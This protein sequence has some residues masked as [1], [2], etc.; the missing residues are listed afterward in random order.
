M[1]IIENVSSCDSCKFSDETA[2]TAQVEPTSAGI[3]FYSTGCPKC[4]VVELKLKQANVEFEVVS[5]VDTVVKFGKDH[6]IG[7]A[8]ILAVG[9]RA[10]DFSQAISY[11]REI[12]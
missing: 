1:D 6:G 3:V 11:L 12:K 5:D 9:D 8:P 2:T 4:K 7:S 10:M